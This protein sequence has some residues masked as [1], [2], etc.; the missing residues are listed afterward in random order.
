MKYS[1]IVFLTSL[2]IVLLFACSENTQTKQ[3]LTSSDSA[4]EDCS[5]GSETIMDPNGAKPMALMMRT[6]V[7]NATMMREQIIQSEQ[8]DSLK[9]PFIRF[10][11]VEPTDPNVLQP[12]FYEN[13]RLFQDAYAELF[14]HPEA[15][16]KYYN[17]MVGKCI[18]CHEM[19]CSGP[20]KRIRK[21][22]ITP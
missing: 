12:V 6:M 1:T 9:Y 7:Q 3:V 18:N 11:L 21:L 13:A 4:S 19:Y 10:Y 17:A 16:S 5:N 15:Q 22:L 20:L 8:L 14:N 2:M